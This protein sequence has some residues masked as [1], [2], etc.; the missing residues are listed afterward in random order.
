MPCESPQQRACNL[1]AGVDTVLYDIAEN[2]GHR[3]AGGFDRAPV[4]APV[5][6]RRLES[7]DPRVR[8]IERE[9]AHRVEQFQVLQSHAHDQPVV[10]SSSAIPTA[11]MT[12]AAIALSARSA[13]ES[14]NSRLARSARKA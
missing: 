3:Q 5:A 12:P 8:V 11:I 2:A 14:L 13:R 4:V 10:F 9:G 7:R 6:H 1:G